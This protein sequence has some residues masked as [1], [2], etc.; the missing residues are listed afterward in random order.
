MPIIINQ[1]KLP[2]E[3][4]ESSLKAYAAGALAVPP[5]ALLGLRVVRISLDARKKDAIAFNYTV[6]ATLSPRDEARIAKKGFAYAK[7]YAQEAPYFGQKPLDAPIIIVGL[8]PAGLFAAYTL[9]KY[10]YKPLI[11]ERGKCIEDREKDVEAYW[12]TGKLNINS[13]V[14]FGEGG[15]GT[16]SDGKLTTRIKDPRA[17]MVVETLAHF[18]APEE[19]KIMAKPHIGTDKLTKTVQ[20][21]RREI[22]RLGGEVRFENT[23]CGIERS[24]ER[25]SAAIVQSS[26][27]EERIKCSALILAAGQGGRDTYELLLKAGVELLPKPFAAGV[28]IE[29]PREMIDRAQYGHHMNDPRLGAA[30]YQLTSQQGGRGVY[31][32]CMCPGGV[33]VASASGEK[34]AVV[35][36]MSYYARNGANSN[37]AIVV[38]VGEK[39]YPAGPLGGLDFRDKLERAAFEAGGADGCA[40]ACTLAGLNGKVGSFSAVTPTY[41]PGVKL[42]DMRSVLPDY[43]LEGIRLGI[44]DFG[45]RL[46]GYDMPDAA[47][48]AVESRTSSPVR[49]P[50]TALGEA[51]RLAGLYPVGEG[52]GYAGGIVSAAV[53]GIKAAEHIMAIYKSE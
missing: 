42:A 52:A 44:T 24:S 10:G 40:P 32:F 2:I 23:L 39:D 43:M 27:G 9:A 46:K 22:I 36:G 48:T 26:R 45:R 37:A 12:Q 38:Q 17:H 15:A 30:E 25:I 21:M 13:N 4:N 7:P 51:T 19:I 41:R 29:H 34:Q 47:I 50:R 28:R 20:N 5:A 49:I 1:L 6:E 14:M 8:G 18:G 3:E 35:N 33:V 31:T 16:F 11:I 53:D